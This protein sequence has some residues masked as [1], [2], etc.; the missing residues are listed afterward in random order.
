MTTGWQRAARDLASNIG[1][2]PPLHISPGGLE[3]ILEIAYKRRADLCNL[4]LHAER[5]LIEMRDRDKPKP[6]GH[7]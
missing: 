1:I 7:G 3:R 4:I 2:T 6:N 5:A